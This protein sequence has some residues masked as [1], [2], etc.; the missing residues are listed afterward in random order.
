M[1]TETPGTDTLV[2]KHLPLVG[3][4]VNALL[5]RVPAYVSRAE[6]ASA[7]AL[8]LVQAARAYDA[9][10][11]VP[12]ERYAALRI[13]GALLDELRGM[14]WLTRGAR[15][16]ARQ[17][18]EVSDELT[19]HLGRTPS[20][21]ELAVA[22]GVPED[23]VDAAR[24]DAE[25]RLLSIEGFEAGAAEIVVVD[26][27]PGPENTVLATERL[28][29]VSA[30]VSSLPERLRYVVEELFF[31]DRPVVELA[32]ELGVTQSRISQLRS[33]AL[34]LLRD[35]MNASLEPGLVRQGERPD[36]VAERRRRAYF[37]QVAA[38]AAH[39]STAAYVPSQRTGAHD[40]VAHAGNTL[41]GHAAVG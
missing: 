33:E 37:A 25:V 13:R 5:G 2:L 30:G 3:Y 14:D 6:L 20:K 8:A 41:L 7:G 4:H 23:S 15:R 28:R 19:G 17:L 39:S 36:G 38:Q 12:F 32:E 35:G 31:H 22:L 27:G 18:A 26:P 10:T 40:A 1:T 21:S 29:Y 9:T 34:S 24:G 11:G 16:R